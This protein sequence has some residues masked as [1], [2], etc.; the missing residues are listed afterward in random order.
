MTVEKLKQIKNIRVLLFGDFMVDK[1]IYGKVSRISPEAPVPVLQVT[2]K[3]TKLG[4]AGNVVNNVMALGAKVRVLGCIGQ[5]NDGGWIISELKENGIETNYIQ[6]F[7]HVNTISKTRLVSKNQ[8]FLRYDEEK[9]QAIP[10][11]YIAYMENNKQEI[12][13]DI[14]VVIIS[15]YGKGVVTEESAQFLISNANERG[16]PVIIDPKGKDYGKYAGAYA[17]TPNVKELSDV[18]GHELI[19][20]EELR[21]A[22]QEVKKN[23][24][25]KNLLLTRSEKGIS[26][27]DSEDDK[28]DF[29]ALSKDVVD[30][31]G[32][33]DTVVCIVALMLVAGF[34]MDECCVLANIAA[35]IVCSK[36][37]AAT[38]SLN[39]L[40]EQ[41]VNSGEFKLVDVTTA[42]YVLDSLREKRKKIVF[43]NG[44]FDMLHAGHLASFLQARKYGDILLVAVNSDESVRR[45]KGETRPVINQND[46]IAMLCA[47]ECVDYVILMEDDTPIN[48][49]KALKPDVTVKGRDWEDKNLPERP[50][51]EEYGGRVC[52]IDLEE[53][54]STTNII[55][56]IINE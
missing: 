7:S 5:D 51:V 4:G 43:T 49:I 50:F 13:Q 31:T 52:F 12:F 45:L 35:S 33:G 20:E 54:L 8:Q 9:I 3:Q 16:I 37:G 53:G 23:A 56:K 14:H 48:L 42:R 41:I 15:D 40:M 2:K 25:I 38:L 11:E 39:E 26:L 36:F 1:Y 28:K 46:R 55:R 47:L 24:Q 10:R 30:V 29:P 32:A 27:F 44:C 18:I 34:S 19:T 22:G 21:T 17:C 6:Q